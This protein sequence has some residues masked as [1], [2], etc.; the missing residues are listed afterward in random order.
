VVENLIEVRPPEG[1]TPRFDFVSVEWA[2]RWPSEE[3]W[4]AR[5][6]RGL[7]PVTDPVRPAPATA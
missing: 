1:A 5:K 2:Q 4:V 3:I 7:Q 6:A